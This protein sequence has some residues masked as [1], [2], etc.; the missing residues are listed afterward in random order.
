[1]P[2]EKDLE[3][4]SDGAKLANLLPYLEAE[5]DK[6]EE[7]LINRVLGKMNKGELTPEEA[8]SA[9]SQFSAYRTLRKRFSSK[10]RMGQS[11]AAR[12]KPELDEEDQ[13]V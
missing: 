4:L 7:G 10:V 11:A 1:M 6:M 2:D 5:I 9:W 3:R 8:L 12:V 13:D